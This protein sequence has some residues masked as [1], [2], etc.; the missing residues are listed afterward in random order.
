MSIYFCKFYKNIYVYLLL[1][2]YK[3]KFPSQAEIFWAKQNEK[4]LRFDPS[5][6]IIH[7]SS[8]PNKLGMDLL[9]MS[10]AGNFK[11]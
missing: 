3:C 6:K 10:K 11:I 4:L 5:K 7:S 9:N 2:Y 8:L 1:D